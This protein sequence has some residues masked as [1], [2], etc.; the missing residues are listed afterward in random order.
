M[1]EIDRHLTG[2]LKN[3]GVDRAL[4]VNLLGYMV[5]RPSKAMEIE[6]EVAHNELDPDN[7]GEI[8]YDE[9]YS[10]TDLEHLENGR[11]EPNVV[12]NVVGPS[13]RLNPKRVTRPALSLSRGGG[14]RLSALDRLGPREN[15]ANSRDA[16]EKTR[17][18]NT[19]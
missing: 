16:Q 18:K 12:Q 15:G 3:P 9:S 8:E 14:S 4:I 6:H 5:Q 19:N 2:L 13:H 17:S 1:E 11:E 7:V 10:E